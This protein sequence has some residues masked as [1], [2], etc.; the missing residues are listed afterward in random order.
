MRALLTMVAIL[1]SVAIHAKDLGQIG[2]VFP[3]A[4]QSL[5]ELIYERLAKWQ[6]N[7][8][9]AHMEQDI[10]GRAARAADRPKPLALGRRIRSITRFF[11]PSLRLASPIFDGDGRLLFP[12]GT[13]VNPLERMPTYQPCWLFV[14]YDD[15]AQRLWA[16]EAVQQ[17][18][19]PKVILTGG[20]VSDAE[21]GFSQPIYFDQEGRLSQKLHIGSVPALVER[22]GNRLRIRMQ[23]IREDGHV[24]S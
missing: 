6:I 11:D 21:K 20:S 8:K 1:W 14:N 9:L 17:C 3:V 10:K 23:A 2:A 12:I 22:E 18:T 7:G 15:T 5:L 13:L 24:L 19:S 4:E 16:R